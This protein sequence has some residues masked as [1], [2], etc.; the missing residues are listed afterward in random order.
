MSRVLDTDKCRSGDC[1]SHA[2]HFF[3]GCYRVV[4]TA[5]NQSGNV[6]LVKKFRHIWPRRH[7]HLQFGNRL[8]LR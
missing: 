4:A 2:L 6:D 8:H 1:I 5:D 3:Y 7:R